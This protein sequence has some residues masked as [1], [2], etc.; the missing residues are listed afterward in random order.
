M[1]APLVL[2]SVRVKFSNMSNVQTR[3]EL[4]L[5]ACGE[6]VGMRGPYR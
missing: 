2:I 4:L 6:E 1:R 5:P 3:H